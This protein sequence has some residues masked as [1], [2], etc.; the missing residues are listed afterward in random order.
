MNINNSL[1]REDYNFTQ[2][3]TSVLI[4]TKN[5]L[6]LLIRC[7]KSIEK[8]TSKPDEVVI[9]DASSKSCRKTIKSFKKG[10]K[11]KYSYNP[12]SNIPQAR[13]HCIDLASNDILLF[14]D[15]DCTAEKDW[16]EEMLKIH[17]KH[18]DAVLISGDLIHVPKDSLYALIIRNLRAHRMNMSSQNNIYINIENCLLLKDKLKENNIRFNEEMIH[19]DFADIAM[20]IVNKN[21]KIVLGQGSKVYHHERTSLWKFLKQRF[22]NSGNSIRLHDKWGKQKFYFYGSQRAK[23]VILFFK[24]IKDLYE[25]KDFVRILKFI[26]VIFLSIF[27]YEFGYLFYKYKITWRKTGLNNA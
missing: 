13:N 26:I 19:E 6:A 12:V 15:D 3:K 11:T 9:V 2:L 23:Y 10:I 22:K 4:C 20:Q 7:L 24:I 18:P 21:G 14:I 25:K 5:R 27:F 1:A 16:I 8:Q 17:K